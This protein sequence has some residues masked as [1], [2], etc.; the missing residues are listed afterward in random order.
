MYSGKGM[1]K[2]SQAKGLLSRLQTVLLL[3]LCLYLFPVFNLHATE[4]PLLTS[5]EKAWILEHP[6]I[7]IAFD[8]EYS[9]YSM[10]DHKG[11][12][13]GIAVDFATEVA[14]RVGITLRHY[15]D[16][17]W[18]NLYM[19]A[20]QRKVDVVATL[21]HRPAREES[22]NF[23]DPYLSLAQYIIGQEG[24]TEIVNRQDV[25]GKKLALVE[26]YSTTK[27]LLE[28]FPTVIPLY[29][30]S[31][32]AALVAVA[33]GKADATVAAIGTAQYQIAKQ[34]LQGLEFATLFVQGK[35]EQR[36]GIRKDWPELHSILKKS[37]ASITD[38]ERQ[39]I[40][41]RWSSLDVAK[42]ESVKGQ[43]KTVSLSI[44]EKNWLQ[45]HPL[46]RVHNEKDW[47]PVNFYE[48]GTPRGYSIDFMNLLADKLGVRVEYVT[49]PSWNEFMGMIQDK[50]LDVMLNIVKTEDRQKYLIFTP[51]YLQNPVS[52]ISSVDAPYTTSHELLGKTVAF[53]KGFVYEEI[54][55]K[56]FPGIIRLAVKDTLASLKAVTF[57]KA[58]A[59]LGKGVV[60]DYLIEKNFLTGLITSG[61]FELNNSD[62]EALRIGVRDDWPLL[63]SALSKAVE[64]VTLEEIQEIREKWLRP[65]TVRDKDIQ[66][67]SETHLMGQMTMVAIS[68]IFFIVIISLVL[69]W[70]RP[71]VFDQFFDNQQSNLPRFFVVVVALFLALV[72]VLAWYALHRMDTKLRSGIGENLVVV[73]NTTLQSMK[74]WKENESSEVSHFSN[75][76]ELVLA[77]REQL[78]LPRQVEELQTSDALTKMRLIYEKHTRGRTTK[79][80][81]VIAHDRTNVGSL[82]DSN[83]GSVNL[84]AEQYP[85]LLER[86]F[87]GET[88]FVPPIYSDV[89]L[90]GNISDALGKEVTIFVASPVFDESKAVIAVVALRLDTRDYFGK[91]PRIGRIGETGETYVFDKNARLLT[92]SRFHKQLNILE[93]L[94]SSSGLVVSL[95]IR[96][97]GGN[98]LDGYQP[99]EDVSKWSLT[100]MAQNG[101]AGKNGFDVEGYRD[102]RGIL[103]MGAWSW[104]DELGIGLATEVDVKEALAPY[105]EMRLVILS[106]LFG[107]TLVALLITA[108]T[109]WLAS[110]TRL[111]LEKLVEA[112]TV[113]LTKLSQ[114]LEQ[115]PIVVVI[116]DKEGSI[117]Y[118]NPKFVEVTGYSSQEAIGQNPRI[119]K[120]EKTSSSVYEELWQTITA[121]RTWKGELQNKMKNGKEIWESISI[122][123]IVDKSGEITNFVAVKEDIT[124]RKNSEEELASERERLNRLFETSP[125]GIVFS[126]R[127][128]IR[129]TNRKFTEMFDIKVG[130]FS[131]NIYVRREEREVLMDKVATDGGVENY[132]LQMYGNNHQVLD[133]LV[134]YLPMEYM[135]EEGILGWLIDLTETKAMEKRVRDSEERLEAAARGANLG[136]WDFFP[137]KKEIYTNS[138]WA[139]M[140]G[141]DP[142]EILQ[143]GEKW[144][145]VNGGGELFR[146]LLHPDDLSS[147]LGHLSQHLKG[148]TELYR[149]EFRMRCADGSWKWILGAG[150]VTERDQDGQALRVNGIHADI[151]ELKILQAELERAREHAEAATRAKSEFLANMSHEIRTPMN[152]IIG[153]SHLALKTDLSPKQRDY[154]DKVQLSSNSLLNIIND[155]LDFS[156][157]EAGR[158][159]IESTNFQLDEVLGSLVNLI[160]ERAADKGL[161]LLFSVD[162]DTPVG[163]VGDPL[164]LGQILINLTNNAV[165]FTEKG[166]IVVRI[167][168][169]EK[170]NT[171]ATLQFAIEDSGIGISEEKCV[172]L[173]QAFAQADTSTTRK[174][175]G[176]GLGL[177]ISQ[178]LCALMGGGIWVESVLG[179][180]S[181][182][183]FTA[184]FG[185]HS[186]EKPRFQVVPN[187]R[188]KQV[189][190][191]DDNQV[192]RDILASMLKA[193]SFEVSKVASGEEAIVD[194]IQ[195]DKKGR[196]FDAVYMDWQMPGGLNGIA[197]SKKIKQQDL[198]VHPKIIMVTSYGREEIM[199]KAE[200]IDI[201]GF[202]IKPVGRSV[203][204]DATMRAFGKNTVE[205]FT[206]KES[207]VE[208]ELEPLKAII[209]A[210]IL[211]AEDNKINQQVAQEI[212]EQAGMVV[213]IAEDGLQAVE[214]AEKG[215]YDIILMDI[216]MPNMSGLEA[217][218][219]IRNLDSEVRNIP[220][221]AMTAHTMSGD[222]E[223][224]LSLGMN[225]HVS[226]PIDPGELFGALLKWVS[227]GTRKPPVGLVDK[228]TVQDGVTNPIMIP[229][230][231]GID[232]KAGLARVGGN[233]KLYLKLLRG[234]INGN[235]DFA[236]QVQGALDINDTD[237][238]E[239]L[240]HTL[241]GV[242]GNLGDT[243]VQ[244]LAMALELAIAHEEKNI[245][246]L[247]QDIQDSLEGVFDNLQEIEKVEPYGGNGVTLEP[248][249]ADAAIMAPKLAKLRE[250]VISSDME[251]ED[252]FL[253]MEKLLLAV[254]PIA[255][256]MLAEALENLD[257]KEAIK[258]LKKIESATES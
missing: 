20:L 102:Y 32:S 53:P 132:E 23:T 159:D 95:S 16:G 143:S 37:L 147:V 4:M 127:D 179:K 250:F 191:V 36:F 15:P 118:V 131:P 38:N 257:F 72:M 97:P 153:M 56:K 163:L 101:V 86:V 24:Q 85:H 199:Q 1:I 157:I 207:N 129:F 76:P 71:K 44:K 201:D 146:Q 247:V 195:A 203:L 123:P 190:V 13:Q 243:G 176:T 252:C 51:P 70:L 6:E 156:K 144:A 136:L 237:T 188:G 64:S 244:E 67:N 115:S 120:S 50:K 224:S 158:L 170:D 168:V 59:A 149:A 63:Q 65:V 109:V 62:L 108:F 217:T 113:E 31:L 117:E 241:R 205:K 105:N 61:E 246:S 57:G 204:F 206:I 10:V 233:K 177:T 171:E 18:K 140:L 49:G 175:G 35:S 77:V 30:D 48:Y 14:K 106:S 122:S 239:R 87:G 169:V 165:K 226:K 236:G 96:D 110:R 256:A 69:K 42:V 119:L 186:E 11:R 145:R 92:E 54:L 154:I 214:M 181:T 193:M 160:G 128:V 152:A 200:R 94:Y 41:M 174:Y 134:T 213:A 135:G 83:I 93:K 2:T 189:L 249:A 255:T 148:E 12:Y 183:Y 107:T 194:I 74:I 238:A 81:F 242:A 45:A 251:A 211:L 43:E 230:L 219:K 210:R 90:V 89:P 209:G 228:K 21:V 222:R 248:V 9:P 202:L 3:G 25:A 60:I 180:G 221:V 216:Q 133:L 66:T 167:S 103:V 116:T 162:E 80:F 231:P 125:V 196:S 139:S 58:D 225:D 98:L 84:I 245:A 141:F 26:G 22:F 68:I 218:V 142:A 212:L 55:A 39:R 234:Y 198:A 253:E 52:I 184:V 137:K 112:R 82:R 197:T 155:I 121:G 208:E 173:F 100:K 33:V 150:R 223:K 232:V 166:E 79:G 73:N 126:T 27:Y 254:H 185:L 99:S 138:I 151:D 178:K 88:V 124:A 17:V 187:L 258:A 240:A 29:V 172:N 229:E 5:K 235:Q 78:R 215:L 114:A 161:E 91:I 130:E 47:A 34:G 8:G 220:I 111:R 227:P 182:F 75:D 192:S 46:L 164:R 40:F 19:A 7:T 104:S 28:E